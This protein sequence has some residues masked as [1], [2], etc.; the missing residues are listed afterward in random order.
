V[1]LG[2]GD[3]K[4]IE[5]Q[6]ILHE[7]L[8]L[9]PYR[10][11]E[12]YLTIGIGLNLDA[13]ITEEEAIWLL[14]SRLKGIIAQLER[15]E[16]YTKLDPVRQKVMIDMA[17]NLGTTG[18]LKFRKMIAAIELGDYGAAADQMLDSRWARQVKTRADRLAEMMR[19]GEDY[20]D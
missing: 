17:Y 20:R 13:G 9:K 10:C 3:V 1:W 7:G 18:L 16:W 11:T 19:T 5:E 6:L 15:Y 14:Q 8:R 12:G 4:S 2:G